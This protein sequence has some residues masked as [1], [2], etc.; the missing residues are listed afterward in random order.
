[1]RLNKVLNLL[2]FLI[3]IFKYFIRVVRGQGRGRHF[4][5]S[6]LECFSPFFRSNLVFVKLLH[7]AFTLK[8]TQINSLRTQNKAFENRKLIKIEV[9]TK[10]CSGIALQLAPNV[11]NGGRRVAYGIGHARTLPRSARS[12]LALKHSAWKL[13]YYA[14]NVGNGGER[15]LFRSLANPSDKSILL[16]QNDKIRSLKLT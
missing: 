1:M 8:K 15:V 7:V 3:V 14:Q 9:P 10:N 6:L 16:A 12:S 2:I 5:H 11:K 13:R 4:L